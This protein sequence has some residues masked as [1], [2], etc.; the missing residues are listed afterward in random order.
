MI[1]MPSPNLTASATAFFTQH[2][3]IFKKFTQLF[4]LKTGAP[5][6]GGFSRVHASAN[7]PFPLTLLRE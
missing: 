6:L 1:S 3:P 7:R 5:L 2:R 4:V